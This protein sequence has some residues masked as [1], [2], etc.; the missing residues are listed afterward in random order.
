MSTYAAILVLCE[1]LLFILQ[2]LANEKLIQT[3]KAAFYLKRYWGNSFCNVKNLVIV[4]GNDYCLVKD[5][6]NLDI[7]GYLRVGTAWQIAQQCCE[8][9]GGRLWPGKWKP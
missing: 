5:L 2:L 8:V 4:V 9:D 7:L 6:V 3:T 1:K